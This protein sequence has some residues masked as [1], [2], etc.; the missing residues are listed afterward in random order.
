MSNLIKL[1]IEAYKDAVCTQPLGKSI[2]AFLNPESYSVN[3]A[4]NYE[5]SKEKQNNAGTQ[6]FTGMGPTG[7]E[8]DLTVDGT[9]VIPL[10]AGYSD[11]DSYIKTLKNIIYDYQGVYHRPN[12]LKIAWKNL[13]FT[14]V[15][16]SLTLKYSLFKPDGTPIR[17]S[18]K[19]KFKENIDFKTKLKMAQSSS[20]DLTHVRTVKAGDT[21]P[22]M[23]YRIYGDSSYYVEVARANN[24]SHF[25][26]IRPGDDIYFPPIKKK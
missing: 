21:L 25:S 13:Q 10:P 26:D 3:Y 22:L 16:E 2:D 6:I 9:G 17:A 1:K 23:T 20:P 8:L 18:V 15:C 11:I 19:L 5:S 14:G 7:L 4:V 24:L 12:Y